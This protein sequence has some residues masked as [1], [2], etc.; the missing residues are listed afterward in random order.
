MESGSESSACLFSDTSERE[1]TC[2]LRTS[3]SSENEDDHA[4][5]ED[6]WADNDMSVLFARK[7]KR[8]PPSINK[9]PCLSDSFSGGLPEST[10]KQTPGG[11]KQSAFKNTPTGS[12]TLESTS[13]HTP[14]SA[15]RANH[16][17]DSTSKHT[18][19]RSALKNTPKGSKTLESTSVHTPVS[20][21][22]RTMELTALA[23]AHHKGLL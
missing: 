7:G 21:K 16:G 10:G 17:T 6:N 9:K 3:C 19:G 15:K 18:P 2:A 4:T 8:Q 22:K 23:N 20:A 14:L 5:E 13:V 11:S 12:K 1:P